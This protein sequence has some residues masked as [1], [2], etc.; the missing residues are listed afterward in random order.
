MSLTFVAA[1]LIVVI[2]FTV[3]SWTGFGGALFC[4]PLLAQFYDLK[5]VVPVECTFEVILS[6]IIVPTLIRDVSRSA[7]F[8]LLTGS[9]IGSVI[10]VYA[11]RSFANGILEVVLGAILIIIALILWRNNRRPP[12]R[13]PASPAI[14]LAAGLTGGILGGI[15]GTP[16]PVYV[17]Y[18]SFHGLDKHAMRATLMV[19]FAIEYT[20]RLGLFAYEDLYTLKEFK[21]ALTLVPALLVGIVVGNF[22]HHRV[23]D[24]SFRHVVNALLLFAGV[25]CFF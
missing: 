18:M 2:A 22:L 9:L 8:P 11:L 10:G 5:F 7:F 20:W 15:F 12:R 16:G 14:G 23:E 4:V 6:V 13:L 1:N 24:R 25:L 17:A 3:R 19:L 21:F